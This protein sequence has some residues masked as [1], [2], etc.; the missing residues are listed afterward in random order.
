MDKIPGIHK[1]NKSRGLGDLTAHPYTYRL[2]HMTTPSIENIL[3]AYLSAAP[4]DIQDGMSWYDSANTL[5]C[6]L[7]PE[8]PARGA[9]VIAALSPLTS[10]PLNVRRA[11]EVFNTGTTT[12][13][14]RNVDKAVR[15]FNGEPALDVLSGPKVRSFYLNIMGVNSL[16]S[17]TVDRHAIDV[18][19]GMVMDDKQRA[20]AIRGKHGYS[21][22]A[23]M[24]LDAA[25]GLGIT[26]AQLQAITWVY[27]RRNHA[28]ANHGD[29]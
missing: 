7:S 14:K 12:G 19:C 16:E 13:L 29:A 1:S 21:T 26:G 18:A 25:K 3:K 6:S 2:G 24:Y 4:A 22:V 20:M 17:V 28:T 5:A 9:G 15:I 8:S 10:W 11:H 27:W 23:G